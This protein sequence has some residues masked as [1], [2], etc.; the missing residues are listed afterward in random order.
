MN[1]FTPTT[2]EEFAAALSQC[3]E[4]GRVLS[5]GTDYTIRLRQGRDEPDALIYPGQIPALHEIELT[6]DTLR[7]G[8]MVTMAQLTRS[9]ASVPEFAAIAHAAGGVG[10][11][12]IRAKAT[13][14]GNLCNASPAGDMLPIGK[15]YDLRLEILNGDGS[16]F[17]LSVDEFLLGPNKT[18][19]RPGQAV[20]ALRA[21]RAR[22]SGWVSAFHKV[23]FRSYVSISRIG[24]GALLRL[25]AAEC[26]E[27]ARLTLGAVANVPIR[28]P[29]A[30]RLM[31][32]RRLDQSLL[33]EVTAIVS[34]AV[35]DNCRPTNRLYKSEAARGLCADLFQKLPIEL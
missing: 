28:V 20:V 16:L 9:L 35:H 12:Q 8:A 29:E 19:L 14:A 11:P 22:F 33:G 1:C 21:D 5:G 6:E 34:K 10:S 17:E 2:M 26:V 4:R 23:G 31:R 3:G 24:M 32:G 7:I 18:A 30:E 13:M 25:D 27:D 15:L